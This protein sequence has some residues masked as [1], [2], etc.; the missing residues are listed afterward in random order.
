[1]AP[2]TTLGSPALGWT[3]IGT[4]PAVLSQVPDGLAH[5]GRPGGAVEADHV[6]SH[7]VEA[8]RAAPISV[9]G[10]HPPG[11]LDGDLDLERDAPSRRDHG[12]GQAFMAAL[13]ARRSK[14]VSMISRS[15]PPARRAEACS[16]YASR[17]SA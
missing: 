5:L 15:T 17:R 7:G 14:T 9:P 3:E 12:P 2:S 1:M 6:G 13:A 10:Q 8:V 16:S 11:Q 4:V